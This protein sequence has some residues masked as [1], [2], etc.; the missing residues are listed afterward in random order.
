MTVTH[1]QAIDSVTE[2]SDL[3]GQPTALDR[4]VGRLILLHPAI[5]LL[6]SEVEIM[7]CDTEAN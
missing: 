7:H 2:L 1:S 5:V 6:A 3:L 4:I